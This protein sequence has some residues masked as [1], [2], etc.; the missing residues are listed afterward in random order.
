MNKAVNRLREVFADDA[1]EPRWIETLPLRGYRLL[2][3]PD[4]P[5]EP[6]PARRTFHS[7]A[8]LPL[9]NL[10]A[11]ETQ[12]YFSDG[13]TDVLIGELAQISSLRVI[14]RTSIMGYKRANDKRIADVAR[15]LNV[16]A[17]VEGTVTHASGKVRITAQL[18]D[19]ATDHHLWAQK[20]ECVLSD[21]L[22]VQTEVA[23]AI[24]EQ[25]NAALR[26][27]KKIALLE[28]V[29]SI[30]RR[31]TLIFKVSS[32]CIRIYAASPGAWN[33]SSG[34]STPIGVTRM[35]S[36]DWLKR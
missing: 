4:T 26:P 22:T 20:Y 10:S 25:V 32:F 33:G 23:R 9:E 2:V 15:E 27:A 35:P 31:T 30:Q 8:V 7:L 14:S 5:N 16:D 19:A 21:V 28:F 1:T 3:K 18:I 11:G 17:I 12:E 13:M 36:P 34:R 29:R 24:A 6:L